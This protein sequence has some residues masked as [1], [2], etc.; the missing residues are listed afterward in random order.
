[1]AYSRWSEGNWYSF[2][3]TKGVDSTLEEQTLSMW[4]T[5]LSKSFTYAE[6]LTFGEK[7]LES[8]YPEA[9]NED[10]AEALIIIEQFKK[11]AL[12]YFKDDDGK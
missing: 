11:D 1:M 8:L 12:N 7:K 5:S 6:L 10:I 2:Y 9:S 4:H 3:N